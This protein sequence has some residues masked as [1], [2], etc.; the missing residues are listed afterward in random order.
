VSGYVINGALTPPNTAAF[1]AATNRIIAS[2]YDTSGNQT[3]DQ[4]GRL[5]GYDAGNH[6]TNFNDGVA[7]YSYDCDGRRVK[8]IEATAGTTVLVYDVATRLIAEYHSDPVPPPAGGGGTSYLTTDHLGST[9]VVTDSSGNVKT[10]YDFLPFGEEIPTDKRPSGVG[11]GGSDGTRHKFTQKER[12]SESGL[13]YFLARYYSSAQGRFTSPDRVRGGKGNPQSWDLYAY[14]LNNP[15]RY[16]DPFGLWEQ[17]AQGVWQWQE[18]DNWKTLSLQTGYSKKYL[19]KNFKGAVLGPGLRVMLGGREGPPSNISAG[20]S[21]T[22]IT[23]VFAGVGREMNRRV[24]ASNKLIAG[25]AVANLAPAALASATLSGGT[26]TTLG[27]AG[28]PTTAAEGGMVTLEMSVASG[29][30]NAGGR[31]VGVLSNIQEEFLSSNPKTLLDGLEVVGKAV[32]SAGLEAG[33]AIEYSAERVVLQNVGG[34][35]TEITKDGV[36]T[37]SRAGQILLKLIPK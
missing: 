6:Q 23:P 27:V 34:V 14:V 11:Y 29:A 37:V 19:K 15:L 16:N 17:V 24:S 26:L 10:R 22:Q 30:V 4:T 35:L 36:V 18:G 3:Q 7:T 21:N 20:L 33:T 32:Q 9:R 8:K 2:G 5:F 1:N 12:D 28:G 25:I 31:L 13:D